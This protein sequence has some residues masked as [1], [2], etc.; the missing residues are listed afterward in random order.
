MEE[1]LS[2]YA[3][4]HSPET[5][6]TKCC[7]ILCFPSKAA[8]KLKSVVFPGPADLA[9]SLYVLTVCAVC[10]SLLQVHTGSQ[11]EL[12]VMWVRYAKSWGYRGGQ[13]GV[14]IEKMHN[15]RAASSV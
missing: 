15:M 9:T 1:F 2:L 4:S 11:P 14:S 8:L 10:Q 12:G 7:Q 13:L 3:F 5:H 6:Q